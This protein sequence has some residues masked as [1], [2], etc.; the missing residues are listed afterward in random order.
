MPDKYEMA[1]SAGYSP[2]AF[3]QAYSVFNTTKSDEG[4]SN[5][6]QKVVEQLTGIG[7]P[8]VFANQMYSFLSYTGDLDK[9][10]W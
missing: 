8:E 9:W 6:R 7:W 2:N 10:R 3:T 5:K 1:R 4:K